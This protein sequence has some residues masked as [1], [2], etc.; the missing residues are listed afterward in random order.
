MNN[1]NKIEWLKQ[2]ESMTKMILEMDVATTLKIALC[3]KKRKGEY[4]SGT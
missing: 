1:P 3:D 2:I 4:N